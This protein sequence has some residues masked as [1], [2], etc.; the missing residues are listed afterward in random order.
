MAKTL[1]LNMSD[2]TFEK[3]TKAARRFGKTPEQI[4][5]EWIEK[6]FKKS[7]DDPLL[8]LAGIFESESLSVSEKHD[9]YIGKGLKEDHG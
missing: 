2:S 9:E 8:K 7:K 5:S 4:I 3:L 1:T 6:Q